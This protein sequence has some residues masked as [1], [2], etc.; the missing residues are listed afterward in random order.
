M[1]QFRNFRNFWNFRNEADYK[2]AQWVGTFLFLEYYRPGP[3]MKEHTIFCVLFC[4]VFCQ[5]KFLVFLFCSVLWK[6]EIFV[7]CSVLCSVFSFFAFQE[8]MITRT[9]AWSLTRKIHIADTDGIITKMTVLPRW[10]V[11]ST[12]VTYAKNM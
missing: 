5:K 1:E 7:F 4:S 12:K 8:L 11:S 10:P 9:P 2:G 3:G 6:F